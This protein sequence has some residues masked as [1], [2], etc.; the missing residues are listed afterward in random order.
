MAI[1]WGQIAA[2][3]APIL[4]GIL[5]N[6][7]GS[8]DRGAASGLSQQALNEILSV[9]TP[10]TK[11]QELALSP[12]QLQGLLN[13]I[14]ENSEQVGPSATEGITT[15][16]R[17][18]TA[19]MQALQKLQEVGSMGITPAE[20]IQAQQMQRQV[21]AS[22]SVRQQ[23]ILQNMA[24]RGVGGSGVEAAAR[25]ASSEAA[26]DRMSTSSDA[27]R[28]EAFNRALNATSQA[29][30][31]G[32]NIRSQSFGEQDRL[33]QAKDTIANFNAQLRT[34]ANSRNIA[35][36]RNRQATNLGAQQSN[37]DRNIALQNQQQVANK[38]LIQQNFQNQ[39]NRGI[40]ASGAAN[41]AAEQRQ[42]AA[43]AAGSMWAGVG[44]GAG[45]IFGAYGSGVKGTGAVDAAGGT[46]DFSTDYLNRK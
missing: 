18:A 34:G 12:Y 41:K 13:S 30:Q 45:K 8:G 38:G 20:Q 39:L 46:T 11:S 10:D 35:A 17:L 1:P 36:E 24:Q 6:A 14:N 21:D 26:A 19:Q 31:L 43:N 5:G 37:A 27:L 40:A 22:E 25:L 33:A 7:M 9:K 23:G 2:V 4:G 28:A 3:G 15:D 44:E 32:G 29:G 42:G 16:P